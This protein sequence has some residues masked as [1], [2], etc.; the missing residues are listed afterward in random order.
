MRIHAYAPR[1]LALAGSIARQHHE[2]WDGSGYPDGLSGVDI[3]LPARIV[4]L[5]DALE[6]L[7]SK[8]PYKPS[9]DW[10]FTK[11]RLLDSSGTHFDPAVC[12]AFLRV[13]PIL[14][15]IDAHM[16]TGEN[17]VDVEVAA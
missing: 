17:Q 3:P 1:I 8:R 11:Q 13:E 12:E 2:K 5:A 16:R 7:R 9:Y 4:A 10:A 15:D 14:L 6:A